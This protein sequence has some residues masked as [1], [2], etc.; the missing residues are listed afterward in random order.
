RRRKT[1]WTILLVII[2]AIFALGI[3][4]FYPDISQ[5]ILGT[6]TPTSLPPTQTQTATELPTATTTSTPLPTPTNTPIPPSAF[7]AGDPQSISPPYYGLGSDIIVLNEDT[8]GFTEPDFNH[9]QWYSSEQISQQI[10]VLIPE[11]Y[12][13]TIGP[14]TAI[15]KMDVPLNPGLYEIFILDTVYSSA[16]SLDFQVALGD[17]LLTPLLGVA[18]VEYSTLSGN[19]PQTMDIWHSLGIYALDFADILTVSTQWETREMATIVAI[20]RI[21]IAQLPISIQTY[22][23]Q[24]PANSPKFVVDNTTARFEPDELRFTRNDLP[25]WGDEFQMIVNPASDIDV[26]WE[27]PDAVAAGQYDVWVWAPQMEGNAEILYKVLVNGIKTQGAIVVYSGNMPSNQWV[28]LG[29]WNTPSIDGRSIRLALQMKIFG[30]A[31]GEI[32]IDAAA[33]ISRQ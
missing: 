33:F 6:A 16:G 24:L 22:Y 32:S 14:G 21:L 3:W 28:S 26:F 11:P 23:D 15:W 29:T 7:L 4:M 9:P 18:H 27:I 12:F 8:N 20:D 5:A 17:T 31:L 10:G 25:A 2:T 13:A 30:G 1:F 19:P